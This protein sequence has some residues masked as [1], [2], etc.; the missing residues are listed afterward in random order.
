MASLR[1][2]LH[3]HLTRKPCSAGVLCMTCH[4]LLSSPTCVFITKLTQFICKKYVQIA[5]LHL[6]S[7]SDRNL[8]CLDSLLQIQRGQH[9]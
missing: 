8:L 1:V 7:L 2:L 3:F 6:T 9:Y 4:L 5:S